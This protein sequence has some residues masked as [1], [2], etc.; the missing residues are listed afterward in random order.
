MSLSKIES[1]NTEIIDIF[2]LEEMDSVIHKVHP[3]LKLALCLVYIIAVVSFD[4]YD[5]FNLFVMILFPVSLYQLSLIPVH[6]CFYK[7]RMVLP[8]ICLVGISNPFFDRNVLLNIGSI[9][10]TG[11]IIS[12]ITI[13][14]KGIMCLMASFLL[15]A[16]TRIED[17][18]HALLLVRCPK[19]LVGI[20]L[21]SFRYIFILIDEMQRMWDNY[22]LR[23][24]GQKGIAFNAWGSFIGQLILRSM[25]RSRRVYDNMLIRG[26]GGE[27]TY[28]M[29]ANE[30][31]RAFTVKSIITACVLCMLMIAVRVVH[32]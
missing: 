26:Y 13:M 28:S 12:F 29:H 27:M 4:K 9:A 23:A 2:K 6:T 32:F 7:L 25:D 17:I 30:V 16:T 19:I 10:V 14:L 22:K 20:I 24:P 1:A 11:G 3:L 8:L 5:Y 31:D 18:S 21:L 15:I